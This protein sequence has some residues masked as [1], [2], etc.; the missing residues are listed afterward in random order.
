MKLGSV[1]WG[2]ILLFIGGVLL[3]ENF[4]VINFYWRHVWSFWP[5]VLII[6][7]VNILFSRN[8]SQMGNILS[9]GILFITLTFLFVKGQQPKPLFHFSWRDDIEEQVRGHEWTEGS[10]DSYEQPFT[11]ADSTR[12]A[13]LEIS[14]GANTYELKGETDSLFIADVRETRKGMKFMLRKDVSDSVNTL[15]F[16]MNGKSKGPY[17][18]NN[19][20]SVDFYMNTWPEWD[21]K[22]MMGAGKVDFD[23]RNYKVRNFNFDGG[24]ADVEVK[25]GDLLPV[26]DVHVKVGVADIKIEIPEG[27]GCRIKTQTGLSSRDFE[28]F[29]KIKDGIYE[30]PNYNSSTKKI[31]INFDGGLSNFEVKRY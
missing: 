19:G 21:V 14:G 26:T 6:A 16:K 13:V 11:A 20:N 1:I 28:G 24:A 31:F 7:G 17:F 27:S 8:N 15:V 5:V 22:V 23:L 9:I 25:I 30:T 2:M 10:Q 18:G 4:G 29:N 12:K 3:L